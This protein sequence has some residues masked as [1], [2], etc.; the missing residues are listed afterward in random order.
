MGV[1]VRVVF[2][3]AKLDGEWLCFFMPEPVWTTSLLPVI[4]ERYVSD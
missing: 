4:I 1:G 3:L 2:E